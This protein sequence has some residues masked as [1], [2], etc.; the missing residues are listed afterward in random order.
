MNAAGW[1]SPTWTGHGAF[2]RVGQVPG[3]TDDAI[4][5]QGKVRGNR[6]SLLVTFAM[7]SAK[8]GQDT[9]AQ[10]DVYNADV[11]EPFLATEVSWTNDVKVIFRARGINGK[12][13]A[14]RE[15]LEKLGCETAPSF[16]NPDPWKDLKLPNPGDFF[17]GGV[18]ILILA[19]GVIYFLSRQGGR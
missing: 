9:K 16:V 4:Y 1:T 15:K 6:D 14:W 7:C 12:L 8:I 3:L 11:V 2:R 17:K 18:E 10:F 13:E 19:A 5:A